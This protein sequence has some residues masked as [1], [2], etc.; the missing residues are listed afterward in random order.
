MEAIKAAIIYLNKYVSSYVKSS[1]FRV[2]SVSP[3]GILDSQPEKF[4]E[5]YTKETNGKGMLSAGDLVG[6]I[7][8]L[9]SDKSLY[10]TGQNFIVD[11]GFTL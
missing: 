6:T 5:A 4:L 2:N 7:L 10:I 8:F 9:L 3:G 11:D 1:D